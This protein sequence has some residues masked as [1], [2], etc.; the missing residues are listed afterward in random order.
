MRKLL[1][2]FFIGLILSATIG[3]VGCKSKKETPT[4]LYAQLDSVATPDTVSAD[5][6]SDTL[7][8]PPPKKAD[9]LFDDFVYAFMKHKRFQ[10]SRIAFPLPYIRNGKQHTIAQGQWQYD[11]IFSNRE[12]Y[13]LIFDNKKGMQVAKDTSLR[14]VVVEELDVEQLHVK[15]YTFERATNEWMLTSVSVADMEKS[16]NRD[17]YQFYHQF[18]TN[19]D[20]QKAH[21]AN[22]LEFTTVDE[23]SNEHIA[24]YISP[25]QWTDFAPELPTSK[26]T[27]ILYGQT[28][29]NSKM[30][31]LTITSLSGGMSSTLTFKKADGRWQLTKLDN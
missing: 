9:E 22:P 8:A 13:T 24:G 6:I 26:L 28:F 10:R 14:H 12:V 23:E 18:A 4:E 7:Q 16:D 3:F 19:P 30:R 27:N 25:A 20:F 21:I 5:T 2:S 11:P 17:F 29:S 31:V 1:L 15:S